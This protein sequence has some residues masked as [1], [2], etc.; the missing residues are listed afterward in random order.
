MADE[1]KSTGTID[2]KNV[3]VCAKRIKL[4]R[5]FEIVAEAGDSRPA[6][7]FGEILI[8]EDKGERKYYC[9]NHVERNGYLIPSD[10]STTRDYNDA[11]SADVSRIVMRWWIRW[12]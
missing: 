1:L 4:T 5:P 8:V 11:A 10:T 7:V 12:Q 2:S 9:L 3:V 6:N